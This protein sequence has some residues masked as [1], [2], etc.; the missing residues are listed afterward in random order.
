MYIIISILNSFLQK[1]VSKQ[2][3]CVWWCVYRWKKTTKSRMRSYVAWW[4]F[5]SMPIIRGA[6]SGLFDGMGTRLV[7]IHMNNGA[8][9]FIKTTTYKICDKICLFHCKFWKNYLINRLNNNKKW[10]TY[11]GVC[12]QRDPKCFRRPRNG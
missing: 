6:A 2:W 5:G 3:N 4:S 12:N 10:W 11:L 8:T 7:S 1:I 9:T